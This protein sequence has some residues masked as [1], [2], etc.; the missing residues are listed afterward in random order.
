MKFLSKNIGFLSSSQGSFQSNTLRSGLVMLCCFCCLFGFIVSYP[1]YYTWRGG[2][3]C[4]RPVDCSSHRIKPAPPMDSPKSTNLRI[5]V[6]IFLKSL[7]HLECHVLSNKIA[8][9]FGLQ[10]PGIYVIPPPWR[11]KFQWKKN[12]LKLGIDPNTNHVKSFQQK[13][14]EFFCIKWSRSNF[15][16]N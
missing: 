1:I 7:E 14:C 3:F 12:F 6:Y 10:I 5:S 4:L 11:A 16:D 2:T 8:R 15:N 9:V 13:S